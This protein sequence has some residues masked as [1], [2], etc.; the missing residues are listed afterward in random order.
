MTVNLGVDL[1]TGGAYLAYQSGTGEQVVL[2]HLT[3]SLLPVPAAARRPPVV[4]TSLKEALGGELRIGAGRLT[5]TC[6]A[7]RS[8][9]LGIIALTTD[10]VAAVLAHAGRPTSARTFLV[11][12]TGYHGAELAVI[13]AAGD[14]CQVLGYD[15]TDAI[16]GRG[17]D[18]Q[19]LGDWYETLR[20]GG[21]AA[22]VLLDAGLW[23]E[24]QVTAA[25]LR[26]ELAVHA[27]VELPFG[28]VET[29]DGAARM[30]SLRLDR[31]GFDGAA[32]SGTADMVARSR[33]LLSGLDLNATDVDAV[34]LVGGPTR[35]AV[36]ATSM[37]SALARPVV[38]PPAGHL[39]AGALICADRFPTA[40]VS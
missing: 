7:A 30:V 2:R 40:A 33:A 24:L 18:Q 16:S 20:A 32:R 35:A 17:F 36:V 27:R 4:F 15:D 19:T 5:P 14:E 37:I 9:G 29:R 6:D 23:R 25:R 39:A 34:L 10:S 11:C 31:D 28:P 38:Q 21:T 22:D 3:P 12:S 13:R 1:G 8:A 26:E